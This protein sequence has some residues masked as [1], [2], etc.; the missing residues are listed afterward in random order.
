[1]GRSRTA[2]K[3]QAVTGIL[4]LDKPTGLT[5]N[6]ALQQAKRLLDARKGGHTGS[7]DPIATGLL[8]L[9]FGDATKLSGFFLEADKRYVARIAL[10]TTTDTGDSEGQVLGTR[11]VA[12][13]A[14][15]VESALDA[16]RGD[17]EQVPP[18][19]S[20]IK[21]NGQPLYKL[22]RQ[23]IEV[24]REPRPVTVHHLGLNEFSP[25]EI[26][27]EIHSSHGF[28][29]R[30]LAQELGEALGCGAHVSGLRRVAVADLDVADAVSLDDL[31]A[32][33]SAEERSRLL[34]AGDLALTHLPQVNLSVDAAF[35]LCR[36][37]PVK[38]A[39]VPRSGWVRLYARDAGF[40]GL[41]TV[42]DDGRVAPK[43]LMQQG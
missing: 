5:S 21:R 40:L 31:E 18:M 41:G 32:A 27:L 1:M 14:S 29:V 11:P 10:G 25:T 3:G 9:C 13:K 39:D 23:G 22:A 35:Y 37:Q 16:F 34:I 24:E 33:S 30:T 15:D 12:I 17:I 8:P 36:G 26:V 38:A 20:A 28:Y 2:R 43:R 7:L 42:L 6:A 19:F 4:L